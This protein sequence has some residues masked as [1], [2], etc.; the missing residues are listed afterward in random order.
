MVEAI[1]SGN[2]CPSC[3]GLNDLTATIC[4]ACGAALIVE[5]A[6]QATAPTNDDPALR[7]ID[8]EHRVE[9][10]QF[11]TGHGDEAEIACGLLR[12]N[13]I[14]CELSNPVLP[15]LPAEQKLWV[16]SADAP[17]ALAL[18]AQDEYKASDDN[19]A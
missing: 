6:P 18:L 17:V 16:N 3:G 11:E 13:G 10:A 7:A 1:E 14:A 4:T 8:P 9:V 15:G 19:A 2:P 12:A 5:T